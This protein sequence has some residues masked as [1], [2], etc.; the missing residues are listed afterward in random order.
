M[1]VKDPIALHNVRRVDAVVAKAVVDVGAVVGELH[2]V[3]V[4]FRSVVDSHAV[5]SSVLYFGGRKNNS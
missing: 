4:H 5:T 2:H 3:S 1:L